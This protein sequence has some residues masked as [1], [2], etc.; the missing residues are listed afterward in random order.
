MKNTPMKTHTM[1]AAACALALFAACGQAGKSTEQTSEQMN[2][3]REELAKADDAREWMK[4]RDEAAKELNDLRDRLVEKQ[5][6][7]QQ[8][9]ADGI[10]EA[11]KKAE[12][13]ARIAEI[14]NN[15]ARIDASLIHMQTSNEVDWQGAKQRARGTADT[16][17]SWMQREFEKIDRKTE[18]DLDKDGH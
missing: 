2:E 18:T 7:E 8:R 6:R 4:E 17:R 12:C 5:A 11:D 14:G 1:F 16:T 9:L 3:N 13:E 15:I 10:K